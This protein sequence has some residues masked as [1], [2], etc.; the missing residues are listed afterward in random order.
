MN[1]KKKIRILAKMMNEKSL[2]QVPLIPPIIN[3]FD[4][5]LND[6]QLSY[7]ISMKEQKYSYQEL[8]ELYHSKNFDTFLYPLMHYGFIWRIHDKYELAPSPAK[9]KQLYEKLKPLFGSQ[10]EGT[11]TY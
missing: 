1:K 9:Y 11:N 2:I 7:L 6:E 3:C 10:T 4:I 8:K 5:L